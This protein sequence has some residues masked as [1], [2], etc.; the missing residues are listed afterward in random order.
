MNFDLTKVYSAETAGCLKRG[1]KVYAADSLAILKDIVE[2]D[3][4]VEIID[5]ILDQPSFRF[6]IKRGNYAFAYLIEEAKEEKWR[7]FKNIDELTDV[8]IRITSI[9]HV[10]NTMPLI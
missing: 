5:K 6:R 9:P 7:P 2:G 10:A 3:C 1:D 4:K 8:W